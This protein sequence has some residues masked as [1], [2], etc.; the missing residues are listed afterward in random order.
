MCKNES[1]SIPA[2]LNINSANPSSYENTFIVQV[3][4]N[5]YMTS[6]LKCK[7]VPLDEKK[8]W[9]EFTAFNKTI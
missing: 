5:E 7:V 6:Q 1:I 2:G 9:E 4:V 3:Q 8:L